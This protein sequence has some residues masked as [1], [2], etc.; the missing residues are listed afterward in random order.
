MLEGYFIEI[1]KK[2]K[3]VFNNIKYET[4]TGVFF[5]VFIVIF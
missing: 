2:R 3:P 5:P 1:L 4:I